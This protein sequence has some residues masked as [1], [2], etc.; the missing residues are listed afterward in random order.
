MLTDMSSVDTFKTTDIIETY[1]K[2]SLM[3]IL[4]KE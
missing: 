4:V 3:Q 1:L 2:Y